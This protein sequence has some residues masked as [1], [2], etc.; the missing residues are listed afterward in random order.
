MFSSPFII[1][2]LGVVLDVF[3][4]GLGDLLL[5]NRRVRQQKRVDRLQ[6]PCG[7]TKFLKK[8]VSPYTTKA[9]GQSPRTPGA[10]ERFKP[11]GTPPS[12][13]ALSAAS[14][15]RGVGLSIDMEVSTRAPGVPDE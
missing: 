15:S 6:V 7:D 4:K 13:S 5:G 3:A 9:P 2:G 1:F 14:L 11:E 12:V 8:S 10:A